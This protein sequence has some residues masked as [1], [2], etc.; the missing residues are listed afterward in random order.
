MNRT[1]IEWVRNPDGT[2]GY[3]WN[4]ITGCLNGCPYCY[5]RRLANGRLRRVMLNTQKWASRYVPF[6]VAPGCDPNDTFAP[7]LWPERLKQPSGGDREHQSSLTVGRSQHPK[8]IFTCDMGELF[9]P[10]LPPEWTKKVLREVESCDYYGHRF[11]LLTKQ[12]QE[13]AKWSPF[14]ENA[15]VGVSAWDAKSFVDA[16]SWL[17]KVKASVKYVSLEP[18]L[19]W[20]DAAT[21][22]IGDWLAHSQV[23]WLIIGAQTKPSIRPPG[24]WV[25]AII[26]ESRDAAAVFLKDSLRY[27]VEDKYLKFDLLQEFPALPDRPAS[28]ENTE[29]R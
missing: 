9:G 22:H 5:A 11:Y 27:L 25:D 21:E 24:E 17:A 8:G 7:R 6:N 16:C 3:T 23:S 15:W 13:L 10:W 29:V 26:R 28:G 4:P 19:S 20:D 12:P 14:P 1:T 18:L 2:P